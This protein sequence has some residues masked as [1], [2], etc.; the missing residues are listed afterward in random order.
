MGNICC[1][2]PEVVPQPK[3]NEDILV[4][5]DS[6]ESRAINVRSFKVEK[7]LG[8]GSFGKVM[9]VTK[10]DTGKLY[11]MKLIS[12]QR[13]FDAKK[14]AHA[15]TERE[16][17]SQVKSP[18]VVK[19]HFAFQ[20][21]Q[22]LYLVLDFMQGGE[23]FFHLR[24]LNKFTEE[25]ARFYAAE[26]LLALEDLHD[27]GFIYRDLKPENVFL[28]AD[29]HIKL[30][31]FNLAKISSEVNRSHTICGTPEYIAPEVLKGH[32]Q[33][34][35]I[36]YWGLG[37]LLYEMLN[38][39]SPF[40]AKNYDKLFKNIISGKLFFPE[41]FSDK[42]KDLI[43]KLLITD[44]KQRLANAADIKPHPF[45][46]GMD[47]DF[48]RRKLMEPPLKPM[49]RGDKDTRNFNVANIKDEASP[50]PNW[51]TPQQEANVFMNFTYV[52]PALK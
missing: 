27:K 45:F 10:K 29:G 25:I 18:F 1:C 17:L 42:A 37:I 2:H 16:V 38:G 4:I 26:V 34:K 21:Y 15:Q 19:L 41:T 31:D 13:L 24:K 39:K 6:L 30:G 40:Y 50:P 11:A 9:L 23:L 5:P 12:K 36:D 14:K 47:W 7:V 28:D 52:E 8:K 44:P 43:S 49:I 32:V 51:N 3:Q 35:E 20:N 22:K 33:G 46:G 48:L